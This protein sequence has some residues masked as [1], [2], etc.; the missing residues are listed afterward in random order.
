[1]AA[2]SCMSRPQHSLLALHRTGA[3]ACGS[4]NVPAGTY[5]LEVHMPEFVFETVGLLTCCMCV[6]ARE[7]SPCPGQVRLELSSKWNTITATQQVGRKKLR[8]PLLL[9]PLEAA[10]YFEVRCREC[11]FGWWGWCV[12]LYVGPQ[13]ALR[14]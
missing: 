14:R 9:R 5:V 6:R 4:R 7:P 3:C 8:Y 1:M 10:Q 12:P 2:L 11:L 13:C